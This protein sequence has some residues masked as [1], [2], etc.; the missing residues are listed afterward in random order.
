MTSTRLLVW[1][2]ALC[3][4]YSG[5]ASTVQPLPSLNR[6]LE[7]AVTDARPASAEIA[8]AIQLR[9]AHLV[10]LM[11][12]D[13]SA[14]RGALLSDSTRTALRV[15]YPD[16]SSSIE[17]KGAWEGVLEYLVADDFDSGRSVQITRLRQGGGSLEV[18]FAGPP[19]SSKAG[20][21]VVVDG[22]MLLR[23]P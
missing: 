8:A 10:D 7:E 9:A 21:R 6:I 17:T 19:P 4:C 16:I 11:R 5:T 3:V 12:S 1:L 22:A 2:C 13:A 14:A 23:A 20:D 15:R 18:F